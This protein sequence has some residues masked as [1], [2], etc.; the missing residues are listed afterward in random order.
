MK[1]QNAHIF[2]LALHGAGLAPGQEDEIL[3]DWQFS[4]HKSWSNVI[5]LMSQ[6]CIPTD[7]SSLPPH[8]PG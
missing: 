2:S 3:A 4:S 7:S 1:T 6:S 5:S 8:T